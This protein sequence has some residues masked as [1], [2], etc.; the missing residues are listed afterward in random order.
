[1]LDDSYQARL[2]SRG[3]DVVDCWEFKRGVEQKTK[4]MREKDKPLS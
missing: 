3:A 1:M 4:S 2:A